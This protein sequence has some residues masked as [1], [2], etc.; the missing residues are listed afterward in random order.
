MFASSLNGIADSTDKQTFPNLD[1]VGW[2]TTAALSP[3]TLSVHNLFTLLNPLPILLI[4]DPSG[5][6]ASHADALPIKVYESI[7]S[8]GGVVD[9]G[10]VEFR[11]ETGEAERIGV[12][13]VSKAQQKSDGDRTDADECY[14][15]HACT[16]I[17]GS[18]GRSSN[19][20]KCD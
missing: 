11:L 15:S 13:H 10:E 2:Y 8:A 20:G 17:N 4:L 18:G 16:R 5:L 7:P 14:L 3:S 6:S 12:E 1:F 19:S 9:V